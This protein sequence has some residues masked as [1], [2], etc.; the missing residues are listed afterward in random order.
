MTIVTRW[1]I[2]AVTVATLCLAAAGRAAMAARDD[3]D[4]T[5]ATTAAAPEKAS[6]GEAAPRGLA[7]G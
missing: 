5:P 3:E 2:A 1:I 6:P 4:R 7:Q